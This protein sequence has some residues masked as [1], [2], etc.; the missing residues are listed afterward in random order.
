MSRLIKLSRRIHHYKEHK[1]GLG[2][3]FIHTTE[4]T[5]FLKKNNLPKLYG[6]FIPVCISIAKLSD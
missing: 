3:I 5:N 2:K 6:N 4:T 1:K